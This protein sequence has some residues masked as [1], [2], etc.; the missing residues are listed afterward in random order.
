MK[1]NTETSIIAQE[2][3][4]VDDMGFFDYN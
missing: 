2:G 3:L 4:P 1:S